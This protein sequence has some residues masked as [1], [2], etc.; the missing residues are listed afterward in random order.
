MIAS[1]TMYALAA[2]LILLLHVFFVGFVVLGLAVVWVGYLCDWT[3]VRNFWFR[4]SHIATMGIVL[5]QAVLGKAC[6]LTIWENQLR[7]RVQESG[8]YEGTFIQHWL[9]RILFFEFSP[10]VFTMVYALFFLLICVTFLIVPPRWPRRRNRG[11]R[12]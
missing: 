4:I 8:V 6:P 3:F 7:G 2:D 10:W 5:A 11:E 9:H 1:N 12:G